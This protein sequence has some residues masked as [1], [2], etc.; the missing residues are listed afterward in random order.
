MKDKKTFWTL[1]WGF[2]AIMVFFYG[3]ELLKT[4]AL[5]FSHQKIPAEV[6]LREDSPAFSE[7][8]YSYS[9]GAKSIDGEKLY[10]FPETLFIE[11]IREGEKLDV[12]VY[13][14][15]PFFSL[16]VKLLWFEV[17]FTVA[18]FALAVGL[19]RK[20]NRERKKYPVG[21]AIGQ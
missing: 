6:T 16:P 2:G 10:R 17:I 11:D 20:S 13:S 5:V 19:T 8:R 18:L 9:F 4:A 1:A 14:A 3:L 12:L 15:Y 7:I 21:P